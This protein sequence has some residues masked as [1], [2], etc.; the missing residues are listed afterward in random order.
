M[1]TVIVNDASP[2]ATLNQASVVSC[3]NNKPRVGNINTVVRCVGDHAGCLITRM[4][5]DSA[6]KT[7]Q[8]SNNGW[9]LSFCCCRYPAMLT[10][11]LLNTKAA[12]DEFN[13]RKAKREYGVRLDVATSIVIGVDSVPRPKWD[14]EVV[15]NQ[16]R[17]NAERQ[18]P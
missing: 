16:S 10:L 12:E 4:L 11:L 8:F 3:R 17:T 7:N 14:E 9:N 15:R 18:Q 5:E 1:I 6:R 2:I 13:R